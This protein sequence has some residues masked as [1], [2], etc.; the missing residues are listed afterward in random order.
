MYGGIYRLGDEATFRV[1][2]RDSSRVPTDPDACPKLD[3][4]SQS[5]KVVSGRSIPI[6]DKA[7]T[8][9]L[10]EL[11]LLLGPAFAVGRYLATMRY[12]ISSYNGLAVA[13][14]DVVEGGGVTG[15]VISMFAWELPNANYI[16]QQRTSGQLYKGKNPRV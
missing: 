14:F 7:E 13:R 16:V 4:Y 8:T 1:L 6:K 11:R 5:A 9:G 2:C 3:I 15:G 12:K 10:F